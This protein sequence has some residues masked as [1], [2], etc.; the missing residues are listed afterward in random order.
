MLGNLVKGVVDG[1]VAALQ[2]HTDTTI[3]DEVASRLAVSLAAD[4]ADMER[5]LLDQRRAVL[6]SVPRL[7]RLSNDGVVWAPADEF[8]VAGELL[9][10][11]P[12]DE[13]WASRGEVVELSR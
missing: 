12:I 8:C 11:E 7:V 2:A 6:G 9:R 5:H 1:V 10:V 3:L 4:P 13:H